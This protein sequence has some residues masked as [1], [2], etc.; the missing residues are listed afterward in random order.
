MYKQSENGR[1]KPDIRDA[2]HM[3]TIHREPERQVH[4]NLGAAKVSQEG[5]DLFS[6]LDCMQRG[7]NSRNT[8]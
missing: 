2:V 3:Y 4:L 8:P 5:S 1:E 7:E 6:A